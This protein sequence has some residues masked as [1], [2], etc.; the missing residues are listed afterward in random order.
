MRLLIPI[1]AA[2]SLAVA[3]PAH[4]QTTLAVIGDV[5]Y[6]A[7]QIAGFPTDIAEINAD[8]AV[9]RVV[10][11]GDIKDG[12]SRCDDSY[13]A[14]RLADFQRFA[15]SFIYTPGD[16]EW[17]D[18]HRANNGGYLPTERLDAIRRTFFPVHGRTLGAGTETVAYQSDAF[19]ENVRWTQSRVTF[20]TVH[21]VGSD[22][23]QATWYGDRVVDGVRKPETAEERALRVQEY[24]TR[25]AA[26][27][28]WIDAAFDAAER[29]GSAA[30]AIGLQANMGGQSAFAPIQAKIAERATRFGK[31]VLLMEG[32]SHLFLVDR[33]AGMP[34]N[35]TRF[36]V[37]GST[38]IPRLWLRLHVDGDAA[39]P[40]SCENVEYRTGKTT[41]CPAPL[42]PIATA[43]STAGG[44]VAPTL[45]LT[46]GAPASFGAFVPGVAADYTASTTATVTSTAGD[47]TLSVAD[48]S[49]T[50]TGK[51]VNGTFALTTPLQ[52]LGAVKAWTAPTSNEVVPITF[53]QSIAANEPLRT[54]TYAKTLTLTLSTTNP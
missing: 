40:F 49:A 43:K 52:G 39:Q 41:P 10:H 29:D 53:K 9:G 26:T 4:A 48:P 31:P 6:G 13:F 2:A 23:N 34:A 24:T 27:L 14:A 22:D 20:A 35:V 33:P 8:P 37:Q 47:A 42:A 36:V 12:S 15:D 17:T 44:T 11:L 28:A 30:V 45:S 54:G 25:E 50:A 1:L 5:P 51:L 21:V 19:P 18:C 32:D 7:E 16:N 46:L 3:A 38:N